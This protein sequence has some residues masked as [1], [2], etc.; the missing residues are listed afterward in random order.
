MKPVRRQA[1]HSAGGGESQQWW[2]AQSRPGS[3]PVSI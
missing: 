3:E 1:R 2:L